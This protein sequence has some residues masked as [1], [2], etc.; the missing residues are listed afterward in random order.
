M[1]VTINKGEYVVFSDDG[2][3]YHISFDAKGNPIIT[4]LSDADIAW[5]RSNPD[6]WADVPG[7]TT[8]RPI[9]V[10]GKCA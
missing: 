4:K 1:T 9:I 6:K 5:L 2:T 3:A 10:K 7:T 8:D